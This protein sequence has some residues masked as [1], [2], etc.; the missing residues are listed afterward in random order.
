VR[1]FEFA[2]FCN[3][4]TEPLHRRC[5]LKSFW[6]FHRTAAKFRSRSLK[7]SYYPIQKQGTSE[8][9]HLNI[10]VIFRT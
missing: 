3:M 5:M 1:L 7:E 4:I 6:I 10:Y 9:Q 2:L 8:D